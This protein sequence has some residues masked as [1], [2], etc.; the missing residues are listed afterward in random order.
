LLATREDGAAW[1]SRL[2][3]AA[4]MDEQ[5]IALDGALKTIATL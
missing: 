5:G 4:L 2:R 3:Q 1:L